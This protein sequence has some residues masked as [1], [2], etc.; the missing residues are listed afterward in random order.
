MVLLTIQ[1]PVRNLVL[2]WVLHDGHYPLDLH[3]YSNDTMLVGFKW[4][5][6]FHLFVCELSSSLVHV[7]VCFLTHEVG[8]ATSHT[9]HKHTHT[10]TSR[11]SNQIHIHTAFPYN[12]V[13]L[14]SFLY[15]LKCTI[16]FIEVNPNIIFCLPSMLVLRTRRMCWNFSGRTSACGEYK[17]TF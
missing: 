3:M 10:H 15:L 4:N 1:E 6:V 13:L 8:I 14:G 11:S 16:T 7:N 2:S 12:T 9:L 5:L 17:N